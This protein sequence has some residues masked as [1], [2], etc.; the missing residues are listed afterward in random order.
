MWYI[1]RYPQTSD[2]LSQIVG[3]FRKLVIRAP[4]IARTYDHHVGGQFRLVCPSTGRRLYDGFRYH[5]TDVTADAAI[6]ATNDSF[7]K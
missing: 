4:N 1:C 3:K 6:S 5:T 7:H 2:E